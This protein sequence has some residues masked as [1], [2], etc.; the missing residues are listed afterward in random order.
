[1]QKAIVLHAPRFTAHRA[2]WHDALLLALPY[3]KRME[4]EGRD[5]PARADSLSGLAL[6]LVGAERLAIPVQKTAHFVFPLDGKP[7]WLAGPAFS[8]SHSADRIGCAVIEDGDVG[9]DVETVAP[10]SDADAYAKLHRWTA[11]EAVLKAAGV[12]LRAADSVLL[13]LPAGRAQQAD[14]RYHVRELT[15]ANGCVS[16]LATTRPVAP[17][18]EAIDLDD[19]AAISATLERRLCLGAKVE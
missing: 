13:D 10:G 3:A 7:H 11:V 19:A 16:H 6:A 14:T 4:L 1:M 12:G 8:V 2:E 5:A 9:F 18:I 17:V 15:L